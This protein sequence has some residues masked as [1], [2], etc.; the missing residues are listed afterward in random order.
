MKDILKNTAYISGTEISLVAVAFIRN[1]FLALK[2][3][4]EGFGI[5]GLLNT[6][7]SVVSIFTGVWLAQGIT[8]YISEFKQKNDELSVRQI[9]TFSL[10]ISAILS[11]FIILILLAANKIFIQHF[12][13]KEVVFSY[14]F[15]F[16]ASLL[17]TS[18]RPLFVAIFQGLKNVRNVVIFRVLVSITDVVFV[19]LLVIIYGLTGFFASIFV[20]SIF[21]LGLIFY[22]TKKEIQSFVL[23][24]F[25]SSIVKKLL[26]FGISGIFL[27]ILNYG[28]Q[29]Y[30]RLIIVNR[31]DLEA[32]GL[33]T[34][35]MA[36]VNYMGIVN[37]GILYSYFPEISEDISKEIRI[38][39]INGYFRLVLLINIPITVIT[40][41]LG[42]QLL[43]IL[44]SNK[45][46]PLSK[47]IFWFALTHILSSI[48]TLFHY[49]FLGMAKIKSFSLLGV[50]GILALLIIP[51]L[52]I[53]K[54]GLVSVAYGYIASYGVT[55]PIFYWIMNK[56]IG[57]KFSSNVWFLLIYASVTVLI[58]KFIE[59]KLLLIRLLVSCL[60]LAAML[61]F[62]TKEE[63]IMVKSFIHNKI[64]LYRR[65]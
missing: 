57:F 60:S 36:I 6:F 35:A 20:N 37:R 1:K 2:I 29:Y 14:Y 4:P 30:L 50:I 45:F 44:F 16:S 28:S 53:E 21:I 48:A 10:F 19:F 31:I 42:D 39:K 51:V 62:L 8:K 13:S 3:G 65:K 46:L 52:F 9:I 43:I 38:K 15:F 11:I 7:F 56:E 54:T 27:L 23:P 61:L 5:F 59:D 34:A 58:S 33:F 64:N 49:N 47:I 55:I 41:L 25:R 17:G 18:L 32:V 40:I 24:S 26:L 12:L 22:L 63:L